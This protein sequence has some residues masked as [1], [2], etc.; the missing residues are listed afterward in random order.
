MP[1]GNYTHTTYA[2]ATNATAAGTAGWYV[3]DQGNIRTETFDEIPVQPPIQDEEI[4][5]KET[6]KSRHLSG[7]ERATFH[8][9]KSDWYETPAGEVC[10]NADTLTVV[11]ILKKHGLLA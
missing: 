8:K 7:A 5:I 1:T 11:D 4:M 10:R 2:N 3:A 9:P 6:I